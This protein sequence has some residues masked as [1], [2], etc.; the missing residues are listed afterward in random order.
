MMEEGV[1]VKANMLSGNVDNKR[2]NT[3]LVQRNDGIVLCWGVV[4]LFV[5]SCAVLVTFCIF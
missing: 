5:S 4:F 2:S 1:L 3:P